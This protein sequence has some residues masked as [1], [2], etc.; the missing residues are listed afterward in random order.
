MFW[1]D[2]SCSE[3]YIANVGDEEECSETRLVSICAPV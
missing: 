3:A 1:L 2:E